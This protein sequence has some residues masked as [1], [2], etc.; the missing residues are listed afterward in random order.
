[1]MM[2]EKIK[3]MRENSSS[4][5]NNKAFWNKDADKE[6][7]DMYAK[8]Y[9]IS[10][11]AIKMG[12][13]ENSVYK[14]IKNLKLEVKKYNTCGK[15]KSGDKCLCSQCEFF[16]SSSCTKGACVISKAEGEAGYECN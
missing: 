1:M 10:E 6:L 13:T 16:M 12:R 2:H 4:L 8:G 15:K 11:I 14:R 5:E 7:S 3:E 9:G